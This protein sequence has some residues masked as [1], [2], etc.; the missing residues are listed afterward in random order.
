MRQKRICISKDTKTGRKKP[1]L[2]RWWGEYDPA[3]DN[4]R[5]YSKSFARKI[6]AE[7]Y[8]RQK[9]QEFD[10]GL[11]RDEVNL[12]LEK[13]WDK[14]E[15]TQRNRLREGTF[16]HYKEAYNRMKN[17]FGS[18]TCIKHI[19]PE[20]IE[21]FLSQLNYVAPRYKNVTKKLS[22]SSWNRV[23]R[24]CSRLFNKALEW[25]YIRSN[26]FAGIKQLKAKTQAWHRMDSDEFNALINRVSDIRQKAFYA[27]LYGCGLRT[28]EAI[29]LLW[30]GINIDFEKNKI[31]IINRAGIDAIPPFEI[32]DHEARSI[33]MPNWV[34]NLLLQLQEQAIP[35]G[36]FVFLDR[37]R[38]D[39][40]KSKWQMYQQQGLERNWDNKAVHD[41]LLRQFQKNCKDA[42]I[43]STDKLTL[44]CIRKS[45]ACNLADSSVPVHTLMKLGGWSSIETC[46][47]FYLQST[48][49]N[50]KK[51]IESIEKLVSVA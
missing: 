1:W 47:Q 34:V 2:V 30:D 37:D 51:A 17:H 49:A 40:V 14:Y 44:H 24:S 33:P 26:P 18:E 3:T 31:T 12:T 27:V 7:N 48:D 13:L 25:Q 45:W 50:E 23:L 6:D 29:N 36:P 35:G 39:R 19:R 9:I 16:L 28:G 10:D 21:E 4:Q 8:M 41:N 15:R 38:W 46:Q 20:H 43:K 32:K 22:D 42:G 5:R 11:P